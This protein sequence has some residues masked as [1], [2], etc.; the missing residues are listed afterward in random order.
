M[1][2]LYDQIVPYK[3]S[4]GDVVLWQQCVDGHCYES[5]PHP[6]HTLS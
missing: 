2:T 5:A 1:P 4:L 6:G 3:R